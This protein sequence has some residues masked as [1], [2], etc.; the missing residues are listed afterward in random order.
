M[1][2]AER[3]ASN[4]KRLRL[5]QEKL[6]DKVGVTRAAV[7]QW[8]HK[9]PEKRTTPGLE[10]LTELARI[11]DISLSELVG[12]P[13]GRESVDAEL[14]RLEPSLAE[15]LAR[16]FLSQISDWKKLQKS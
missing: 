1:S 13:E 3:I 6:G 10:H 2:I 14:Q 12:T 16:S 4:R 15:I 11:F 9:D 5:S 7:S 8:E